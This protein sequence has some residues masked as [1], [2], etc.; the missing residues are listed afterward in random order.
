MSDQAQKQAK[1][2]WLKIETTG[3]IRKN[4]GQ[5]VGFKDLEAH[6]NATK[7]LVQR[8]QNLIHFRL[9]MK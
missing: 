6:E 4:G 3:L 8:S 5:C 9:L 2:L 7:W 1:F